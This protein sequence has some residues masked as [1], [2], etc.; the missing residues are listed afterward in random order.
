MRCNL[1]LSMLRGQTFDGASNMTGKYNETQTRMSRQQPLALFV[2]CLVHCGNL[3]AQEAMEAST[4][5]RDC[6]GLTNDLA[7]ISKQSTKLSAILKAVQLEHETTLSLIRPLYPTR[8]LCRCP[9][10]RRLVNNINS[11]LEALK[12]YA[13]TSAGD[14]AVKARDFMEVIGHGNF[15]LGIKIAL[16]VLDLIENLNRAVQSRQLSVSSIRISMKATTAS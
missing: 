1:Q 16:D 2:H 9:A 11:V 4:V 7:I 6:S 10:L 15:V 5:I 8:V 14:A 3:A 13:D 12:Q